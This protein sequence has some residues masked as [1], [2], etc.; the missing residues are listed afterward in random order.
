M[1]LAAFDG[2]V[3]TQLVQGP[4]ELCKR[5][6]TPHQFKKSTKTPRAV[7]TADISMDIDRP[8]TSAPRL[9]VD[10]TEHAADPNHGTD[11]PDGLVLPLLQVER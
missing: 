1:L 2:R 11:G 7:E 8:T 5:Y 9:P 4:V 6:E 3:R 10:A